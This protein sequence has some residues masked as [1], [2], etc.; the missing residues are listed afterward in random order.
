MRAHVTSLIN[1][2]R[3][4]GLTCGKTPGFWMA[5][6]HLYNGNPSGLTNSKDE[7]RRKTIKKLDPQ[8]IKYICGEYV[9]LY[10]GCIHMC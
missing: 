10:V 4:T 9:H 3:L 7:V 1:G 5:I 6:H 2:S 8:R